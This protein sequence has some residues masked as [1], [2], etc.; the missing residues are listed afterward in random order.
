VRKAG[1]IGLA[2]VTAALVAAPWSGA[3]VQHPSVGANVIPGQYVVVYKQSA[4]SVR[5]ETNARERKLGF[6]SEFRYR[7]AMKGF[8]GTLSRGQVR[9]L[10]NDPDV[11][12]VA[13]DRRLQASSLVPVAAGDTVPTGVRRIAAATTTTVEHASG[14]GVAVLDTGV[15][16]DHPDLDVSNGANCVTPGASADDDDGHGTHVA[17][18]IAARNDGSGV[19][20]VAPGTKIWAVKVL[21]ETGDGTTSSIICGLEW[22]KANAA[23]RN[24]KV[25][26]M[27]LGGLGDAVEPCATTDDPLHRAVCAVTAA[28]VL[29]VVAAGNSSWEFDH[30]SAPD[31]PAAYPEVLTVTAMSDSD[32]RSGSLGPS[33]CGEA[34]DVRATFSNFASTPAG[35]A[36]TIAAPGVCIGSTWPGGGSATASGTSMAAPHMAGIAAL[37]ESHAGWA[38]ACAGMTPAQVI[39]SL[40]SKAQSYTL[41]NPSYGF[42]FDPAHGPLSG[43]IFSYLIRAFDTVAPDTAIGSSPSGATRS[44]DASFEFSATEAGSR[45]ECSFDGAPWTPCSAPQQLSG[46]SDGSHALSV[47]AVD[48]AG[49]GDLSPA[50]RAWSVDAT[51]PETSIDSAPAR[52]TTSRSANFE[53]SSTE[54]PSFLRCRLDGGAWAECSSPQALPRLSRGSHTLL[55]AALD[56]VGNVDPTPAVHRWTVMPALDRIKSRLGADLAIVAKALKRLGIRKL[57]KRGGFAARGVDALV[58]GKVFLAVNGTPRGSAGVARK[59]ALAKGSRSIPRAGRYS[60]RAKLTRKGRRLLRKDRR[61][62]VTL[63]IRFRDALGRVATANRSLGLRR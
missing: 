45:F 24:I 15:D 61:A 42:T 47:R 55:V 6:E 41:G 19:T 29:S 51:P 5:A 62:T 17:G 43:H 3:S 9:A 20:G 54:E 38:G 7:R 44:T 49:N 25:A 33:S 56:A 30:G 11:A 32:G 14:V 35:D 52:E 2:G 60:L 34:D 8:A 4:E 53:L 21:D 16:L 46:L 13:P 50:R 27:S 59:I 22:V 1:F 10:R 58:G 40:R 57:V 39:S 23:A 12:Y 36:H 31:L 26:N 63:Q 28:D 18:T 37:C 48:G